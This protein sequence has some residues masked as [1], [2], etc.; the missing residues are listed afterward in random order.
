MKEGFSSKISC[1][2]THTN[3]GRSR[4]LNNRLVTAKEAKKLGT[5]EGKT[6]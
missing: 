2:V 3:D 6:W 4:H 1:I 5:R